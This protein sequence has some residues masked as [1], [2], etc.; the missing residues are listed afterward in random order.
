M[1]SENFGDRAR[2]MESVKREMVFPDAIRRLPRANVPLDGVDARLLQ[3]GSCQML[4]MTFSRDAELPEHSHE[5]QWGVVLE[6][7]I[8]LTIDG[9]QRTLGKGDRYFIPAGV[10][11][12]ATIRAGYADITIFDAPDRYEQ[13][14]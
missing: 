7:R 6:G 14:P 1:D 2:M 12:A 3:V 11:H 5:A 8:D 13:A 9:E 10:P 4:F